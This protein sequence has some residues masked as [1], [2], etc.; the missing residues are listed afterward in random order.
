M[1]YNINTVFTP[2]NIAVNRV[3]EDYYNIDMH[4]NTITL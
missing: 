3:C 4:D 1:N 2:T